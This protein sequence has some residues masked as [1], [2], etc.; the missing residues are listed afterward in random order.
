MSSAKP[1][2]VIGGGLAGP[3]A[4][5]QIARAG[6]PVTLQE[7]RPGKRTPA[8]QTD[9]LGELVCSN[10]LKSEKESSAPWTLKQEL[11]R[12]GSLSMR[13]AAESRVPA[14]HALTVD[15][16]L[17]AERMQAAIEAEPLIELRREEATSLPENGEEIVVVASG[18]LTSDPLAEAIGKL[19]GSERLF[20]FDAISPIVDA[21][22]IDMS[23]A[24]KASRWGASIDG[25]DDYINC[26]F[27]R[28]Q[29]E[30]FYS[31]LTEA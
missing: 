25:S 9:A 4:A 29:Y 17:F 19:T 23:V 7:M 3:E 1:I 5:W 27:E 28:D 16:E 18:P 14:G 12:M 22:T 20:F 11:R 21:E 8:H 24:Y 2:R 15:R 13:I 26:P 30:T 6:L 31:A 10:S